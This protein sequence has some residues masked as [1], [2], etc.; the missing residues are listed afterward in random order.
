VN[1]LQCIIVSLVLVSC[2]STRDTVSEKV[3]NFPT[4]SQLDFQMA[5]ATEGDGDNYVVYQIYTWQN[6]FIANPHYKYNLELSISLEKRK[7]DMD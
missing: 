4:M 2:S 1:K 7:F 6:Q 5:F 3:D